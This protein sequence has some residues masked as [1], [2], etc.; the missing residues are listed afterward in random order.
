MPLSPALRS[1]DAVLVDLDGCLWV[2]DEATPRAQEA[3]EAVRAGGLGVA[4]LTNDARHSVEDQ[5]RKLW[6]LGFRASGGEVVTAGAAVQYILAERSGGTAFVVGSEPLIDHVATAG[7]R[8]VNNTEL[9][10]RAD[11]VVVAHH[12]HLRYAELRAAA[13]AVARGAELIGTTREPTFPMPDGPWPGTGAILAAVEVAGGRTA[14]RIAGKPERPMY[15]AAIDRL[16][17]PDRVLGIGDRM[18]TDI[19]GA[20]GAGF[21]AALVLTGATSRRQADVEDGRPTH[22]AASFADLVLGPE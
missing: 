11:V 8:V 17:S 12:D 6:Q 15:D 1:Y 22:I 5:V 19:A 14:D 18:E 21:D 16:G 10:S 20:V 4:F 2:G 13:Q 7:M 9:A 3:L